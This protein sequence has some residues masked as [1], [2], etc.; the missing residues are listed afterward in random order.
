MYFTLTT[1]RNESHL[2]ANPIKI[3]KKNN[4]CFAV[5][6]SIVVSANKQFFCSSTLLHFLSVPNLLS[7]Y[8]IIIIVVVM[9]VIYTCTSPSS[10]HCIHISF[11]RFSKESSSYAQMSVRPQLNWKKNRTTYS[12]FYVFYFYIFADFI[13]VSYWTEW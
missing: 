3:W 2:N 5:I 10:I 1:A 6:I 12:T 13:F 8:I 4:R 9:N 11:L 7:I